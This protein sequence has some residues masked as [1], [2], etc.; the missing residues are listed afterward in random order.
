MDLRPFYF[1]ALDNLDRLFEGAQTKD[2][3][4][5]TPCEDWTLGQLMNHIVGGVH[6]FARALAG[7]TF[8][9]GAVQNPPD[10]I[11]DDP[12]GAFAQAHKLAVEA[13][14]DDA[15]LERTVSIVAGSVPAPMALRIALTE[16]IVHG[17]DLAKA[18]DQDHGMNPMVSAA[19]L[20]GLRKTITDD[21]RGPGRYFQAE[22]HVG[23]DAP[24]EEQLVAFLGRQP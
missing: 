1:G 24:V 5:Q 21:M 22:V 17:W 3:S 14:S 23:A 15:A 11:G 8:S 13:W 16:A 19:M 18:T 7:E 10:L 12:A 20:D 4:V 9:T 6:M 2:R